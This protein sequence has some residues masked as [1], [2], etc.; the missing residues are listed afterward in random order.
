MTFDT[1]R[2]FCLSFPGT[3]EKMPFNESTLVFT[4]GGKM[5]CLTDIQT[6]E[7]VNLKCD[8]EQAVLLR[9]QYE[10]V[11]P[12]YH[13]N[14]RHW[15]TISLTGRLRDAQIQEWIAK[16]YQLVF[17]SLPKAQR[18]RIIALRPEEKEA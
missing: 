16:S 8:P 5:F 4:V 15:N 7:T 14:K 10:E 13:M 12:G 6:C 9:A 2:G 17:K 3:A 18:E 11:Q 1:L